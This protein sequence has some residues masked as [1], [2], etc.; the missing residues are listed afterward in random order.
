MEIKNVNIDWLEINSTH[1]F[2][3]EISEQIYN[4]KLNI[5]AKNVQEKVLEL[6]FFNFEECTIKQELKDFLNKCDLKVCKQATA[7][8]NLKL[9]VSEYFTVFLQTNASKLNNDT[10]KNIKIL[11]SSILNLY[12]SFEEI[13]EMTLALFRL[14]NANMAGLNLKRIDYCIDA[15]L[16]YKDFKSFKDEQAH[17]LRSKKDPK[18]SHHFNG[19]NF[20]GISFN[21]TNSKHFRIYDKVQECIDAD[22]YTE[23]Q[24]LYFKKYLGVNQ[25][26]VLPTDYNAQLNKY[27]RESIKDSDPLYY[28]YLQQSNEIF[29]NFTLLNKL[30]RLQYKENRIVRFEYELKT[31]ALKRLDVNYLTLLSIKY[32]VI[33]NLIS[34]TAV[35]VDIHTAKANM[36][37]YVNRAEKDIYYKIKNKKYQFNN[38]ILNEIFKEDNLDFVG[39]N[40]IFRTKYL[41]E[42]TVNKLKKSFKRIK[43]SVKNHF[44]RLE[45]VRDIVKD[46]EAF[47]SYFDDIRE[48]ILSFDLKEIGI[49][50]DKDIM[51]EEF[52][53]ST[54]FQELHRK[55]FTIAENDL[56]DFSIDDDFYIDCDEDFNVLYQI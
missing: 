40:L 2:S 38:D 43:S 46:K 30:Y 28:E 26:L 42:F 36:E 32:L 53:S 9:K 52:V 7:Y 4:E 27:Y 49:D 56:E 18:I 3:V 11:A 54:V 41:V 15:F 34:A 33:E 19:E 12:Y 22:V 50:M 16:P 55:K 35:S 10:T 47:T 39:Q 29:D 1:D 13:R 17:N 5:Q 44:V 23:K 20:T 14:F 25:I 21:F 8:Y 45:A 24:N 31:D 51:D 37:Y 6:E 48:E